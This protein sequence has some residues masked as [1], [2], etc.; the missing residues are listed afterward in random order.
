MHE[1]YIRLISMQN[2]AHTVGKI[3]KRTSADVCLLKLQVCTHGAI[4][5][6]INNSNMIKSTYAL[7][8]ENKSTHTRGTSFQ[9]HA[10]T[11]YHQPLPTGPHQRVKGKSG[12]GTSI[13]KRLWKARHHRRTINPSTH[14]N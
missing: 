14:K 5:Q 11:P 8:L 13:Q 1:V 10:P 9:R 2:H 3:N 4:A 7:I 12:I 6:N